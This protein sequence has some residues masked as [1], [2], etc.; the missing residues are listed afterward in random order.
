MYKSFYGFTFDPFTKDLD[1]KYTYKSNDFIQV[2]NRLDYLKNT[3]G[4]ALLTGEPGSGKSFALRHYAKELNPSL[5]KVIYIPISTLT[6]MDFYKALC[7]G[8]GLIPKHKKIDMFHQIQEAIYDYSRNK[9]ITPV[10]IIDEAQF[11]KHSVLDDF[12]I[13]FNFEMDS[14]NYAILIL[15]GQLPLITQLSRQPH[16][17]LRQRIVLNYSFKGLSKEETR[18]Y[19][20]SRLKLAGVAEPIFTED[21]YELIYGSTNGSVRKINSLVEMALICGFKEMTKT[22]DSEIIYKAQSEISITA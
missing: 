3:K 8:L 16:E 1:L 9:N 4:F 11:I 13:I 5:F 19:I 6:V 10:I 7:I 22:I 14:K 12:R 15:S 21:A 17:A 20:E 2:S 18:E